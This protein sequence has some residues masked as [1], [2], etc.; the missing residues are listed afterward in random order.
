M[1]TSPALA[2]FGLWVEQLLAESL[3]K[4]GQGIIPVAGEPALAPD[5][6]GSDRLI[7]YLQLLEDDNRETDALVESLKAN[8]P[9]VRIPLIDRYELG[10]EFL[11]MGICHRSC[12]T[13]SRRPPF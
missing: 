8:H 12:R 2:G 9:I 10:R 11:S 3:G 5:A 4:D 6:Y 1:I 13:H 7:V